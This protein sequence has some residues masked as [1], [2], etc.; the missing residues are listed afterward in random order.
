MV[1][2]DKDTFRGFQALADNLIR[3]GIG[4]KPLSDDDDDFPLVDPKDVIKG[5]QDDDQDDKDKNKDDKDP[6]KTLKKDDQ[7]DDKDDDSD[8]DTND[9]DDKD[10]DDDKT[11]IPED[12]EF[13]EEVTKFFQQKFAEELGLDFDETE[14]FKNVSELVKHMEGIVSEASKPVYANEEVGKID[15]FVKGGGKIEDYYK[16]LAT[17]TINVDTIDITKESN[18]KVVIEEYLRTLGYT[19]DRVRKY[20]DRYEDKGALEEE[21]EDALELLKE[22]KQKNKEKLLENQKNYVA[23]AEKEQQKFISNVEETIKSLS[24]I[25]GYKLSAKEKQELTDYIFKPTKDGRTAYQ[26]EY[27]TDQAKNL[28]ESA[29]FIKNKDAILEKAKKQASTNT[30]KDMQQKL[31]AKG[32]RTKNVDDQ[33]ISKGSVQLSLLGRQLIKQ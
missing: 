3:P 13:E 15:T 31:K 20:V 28:I 23:T 21:A 24:D 14:S 6:D 25:A 26:I 33:D 1:D 4:A 9:A 30:L 12:A 18:Q 5:I 10:D 19:E 8:D 29:F 27:S 32:K 17:G 16:A 2:K 11:I 7:D 22:Y